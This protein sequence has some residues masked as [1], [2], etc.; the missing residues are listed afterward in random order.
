[1]RVLVCGSTGCVGSAVVRA[2][3]SRGHAVIEG[4]RRHAD[5]R[6]TLRLD[7]MQPAAP[8]DWAR[9]LAAARIDAV[10]NCVG[11]LMPSRRQTFERV[12][13]DGPIELFKGAAQ[14]GVRRIVQ[15]SA[16]GV[17]H[18]AQALA[19]PYLYSKLCADDALASLPLEWA[20]LR[21]SLVHGPRSQSAAL[22]ATL[23]SLPV[24]ALPG[25]GAQRVQ[26]IHVY[27]LA[28]AIVRL[29][30]GESGWRTVHQLG[31][32]AAMSYREMLATYRAA[33]GRA[34]ALWLP[35]PMPVMK[36]A[37]GCAEWLPQRVYCR[38]TLR[39]L[40]R[41]S[42]TAD[43]AAPELL[44]RA[45]TSLARG[46]AIAPASPLLSLHAELSP[47]VDLALR[48]SLAFMWIYTALIS[49]L[50]PQ[51][52]GVMNLLARCGFEGE[53]G[54]ALLVASCTLNIALGVATL[55]R[56]GTMLYA[57][58]AAAVV[59]YTTTAALNM[60]ELTLDHCGPLVKNLP[61]LGL[62][63]LLWMSMKPSGAAHARV[64]A[65]RHTRPD[66]SGAANFT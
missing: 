47:P 35:L 52:S 32:P 49:A 33:Q 25:T 15:V 60:P 5:G 24:I 27:E 56:P 29:L 34:E 8:A 58:Q 13:A 16:L 48:A 30:E 18:D 14:A 39:L 3:R 28:E 38:D 57:L 9:R 26:P 2:L 4:A 41:G 21:P 59:G 46:L 66:A 22:F 65:M 23:A 43:N 55:W 44:G 36:L 17:G 50:W 20:V 51:A 42:V 62:V 63:L 54:V 40:E 45:P 19:M 53:A 6:H 1:M 10:V 37:A 7:Y 12:H 64:P 61:V 11:I 31:G